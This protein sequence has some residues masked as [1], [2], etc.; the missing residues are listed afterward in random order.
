[1]DKP[2]LIIFAHRYHIYSTQNIETLNS[3]YVFIEP[4]AFGH[5]PLAGINC[6][7]KIPK[8]PAIPYAIY[9]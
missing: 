4:L 9:C 6:L 2:I 8:G 7:F 5:F 1:M 3:A